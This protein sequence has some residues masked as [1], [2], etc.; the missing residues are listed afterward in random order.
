ME[1]HVVAQGVFERVEIDQLLTRGE[2]PYDSA[3][4]LV[5]Q[6]HAEQLAHHQ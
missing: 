2:L 1:L 3:R 6:G 5:T 4:I